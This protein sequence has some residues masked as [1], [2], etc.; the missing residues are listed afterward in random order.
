MGRLT[1]GRCLKSGA[2][3]LIEPTMSVDHQD[4]DVGVARPIPGRGEHG[5]VEAALRLKN[6]RRIDQDDLR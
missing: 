1:S 5:A 2:S 4:D 6:A 3:D